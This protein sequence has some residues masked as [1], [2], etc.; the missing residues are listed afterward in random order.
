MPQL[1]VNSMTGPAALLLH[2][3]L[4]S[5]VSEE[6]HVPGLRT[7]PFEIQI[8]KRY[9]T[10]QSNVEGAL[11][12][13]IFAGLSVYR[14]GGLECKSQFEHCQRTQPEDLLQ[15]RRVA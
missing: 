11:I 14:R 13:M 9:Q 1:S 10:K 5:C 12:A 6:A 4:P 7:L 2:Q 3:W 15:N 8:I